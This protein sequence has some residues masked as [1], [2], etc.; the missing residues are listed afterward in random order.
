MHTSFI[1]SCLRSPLRAVGVLA[2]YNVRLSVRLSVRPSVCLSRQS[3]AAA[4][5]SWLAAKK[6]ENQLRAITLATHDWTLIDHRLQH[7]GLFTF[8]VYINCRI[9]L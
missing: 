2:R 5:C 3:V 4:T 7:G 6:F 9:W 8:V 1:S